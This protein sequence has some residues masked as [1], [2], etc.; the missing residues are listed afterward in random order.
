MTASRRCS[1]QRQSALPPAIYQRLYWHRP[2]A[3]D[4]YE[5]L[6]SLVLY[7]NCLGCCP[8]RSNSPAL[9]CEGGPL[10]WATYGGTLDPVPWNPS[11]PPVGC[12]RGVLRRGRNWQLLTLGTAREPGREPEV[13]DREYSVVTAAAFPGNGILCIGLGNAG[14][15]AGSICVKLCDWLRPNQRLAQTE[16]HLSR[17]AAGCARHLN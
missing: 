16:R 3:R 14:S 1:S 12:D 6:S 7:P 10:S 2:A 15:I 11:L 13:V 5:N 8:A 4:F 9:R 17:D